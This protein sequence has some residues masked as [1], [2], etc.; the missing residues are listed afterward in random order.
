[1]SEA[2]LAKLRDQLAE[3]WQSFGM[4]K[5]SA[6][7][8]AAGYQP[9]DKSPLPQV[10]LKGKS[11]QEIAAMLQSA[12]ARKDFMLANQTLIEFERKQVSENN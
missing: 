4:P 2:N 1:M 7:Q 6:Q 8:V 12:L 11:D 3:G 10:S 5:E 9:N